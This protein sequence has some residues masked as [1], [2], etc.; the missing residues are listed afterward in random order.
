MS[1]LMSC[2]H[3]GEN[4]LEVEKPSNLIPK[5]KFIAI[6]SD[7]V[8]I[9][10]HIQQKLP[11]PE[12]YALSMTRSMDTVLEQH[13]V[14]RDQYTLSFDYYGVQHDEIKSIYEAVFDTVTNRNNR[15]KERS[16]K[17]KKD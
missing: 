11:R 2:S 8:V 13:G 7:V 15:L 4:E 14:D 17:K 1:F 16:L 5:T 12:Q 9:E 6:M 10:S 3:G